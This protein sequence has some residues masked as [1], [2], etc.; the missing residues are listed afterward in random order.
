MKPSLTIRS[1]CQDRD[2]GRG[3][4]VGA[5]AAWAGMDSSAQGAGG[6]LLMKRKGG[7]LEILLVSTTWIRGR[8]GRMICTNI[9][10]LLL[11]LLELVKGMGACIRR[12][13]SC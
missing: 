12:T 3:G 5:S 10:L 11:E 2:K 1:L 4:W 9:L 8:R 7:L 13:L 6:G